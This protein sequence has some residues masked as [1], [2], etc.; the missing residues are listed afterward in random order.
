MAVI[1]TV[2][3]RLRGITLVLLHRTTTV[4]ATVAADVVEVIVDWMSDLG[5]FWVSCL[6]VWC[7]CVSVSVS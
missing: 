2:D 3:Y 5:P 7:V 4:V 6:E 1:L